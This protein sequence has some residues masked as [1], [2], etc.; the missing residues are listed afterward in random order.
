MGVYVEVLMQRYILGS[1]AFRTLGLAALSAI[2]LIPALFH[3]TA[4]L[5]SRRAEACMMTHLQLQ[6]TESAWVE[7]YRAVDGCLDSC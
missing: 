3:A 7:C 4:S 5:Q 1:G 2:V 6:L